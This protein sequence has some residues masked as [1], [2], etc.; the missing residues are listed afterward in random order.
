ML[1]NNGY[2]IKIYRLWNQQGNNTNCNYIG[3]TYTWCTYYLH[4][5]IKDYGASMQFYLFHFRVRMPTYGIAGASL[6]DLW[7]CVYGFLLYFRYNIICNIYLF[8]NDISQKIIWS[9]IDFYLCSVWKKRKLYS[10]LKTQ[11]E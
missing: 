10:Y 8:T 7:S 11:R 5:C 4:D 3:Y 1:Y 6:M 9:S 2:L